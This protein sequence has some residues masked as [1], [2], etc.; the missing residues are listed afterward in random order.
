MQRELTRESILADWNKPDGV[1][2]TV[3]HYIEAIKECTMCGKFDYVQHQDICIEC[4]VS[5][6]KANRKFD[7]EHKGRCSMCDR[8]LSDKEQ[9]STPGLPYLKGNTCNRCLKASFG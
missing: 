5:Y 3:A 4:M 2:K 9:E 1:M 6:A 7:E 8:K